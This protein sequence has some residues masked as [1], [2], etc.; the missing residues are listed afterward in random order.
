MSVPFSHSS[1]PVLEESRTRMAGPPDAALP[2]A[3]LGD[4]TSALTRSSGD[5]ADSAELPLHAT[6]ITAN[7]VAFPITTS[8]K[9]SAAGEVRGTSSL[10]VPRKG[11]SLSWRAEFADLLANH[12]LTAVASEKNPPDIDAVKLQAAGF[13]LATITR[14][15]LAILREWRD[16]ASRLYFLVRASIDLSGPYEQKGPQARRT[17]SAARW[18]S[19]ACATAW[20]SRRTRLASACSLARCLTTPPWLAL[21][22]MAR[23]SSTPTCSSGP[24]SSVL[25]SVRVAFRRATHV[26]HVEG[27]CP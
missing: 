9:A 19:R 14:V 13:P 7:M 3:L 23:S 2:A 5:P 1:I 18:R 4:T 21:T 20:R 10:L 6:W 26:R 27:G 22:T 16:E 11:V 17:R 24:S 8:G 12:E 15:H 25:S